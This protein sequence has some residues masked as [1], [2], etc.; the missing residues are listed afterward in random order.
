MHEV[1][2]AWKDAA[3]AA[4]VLV[5]L[6]SAVVA[7]IVFTYTR[8]ANRRRATL[9]MVMKTLLDEAAR[10]QYRE[11]RLI[12]MRSQDDDD[13][14]KIACL[15]DDEQLKS[16]ERKTVLSQLNVYELMALGIRRKLF[17]EGLYKRWYHNQFMTDYEGAADFI[18]RLQAK[19]GSIY[20]E[21]TA[22][23]ASW[24]RDGHPMSSPNRFKMAW[25]AFRKQHDKIDAARSQAAAR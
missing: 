11:F 1:L 3:P 10:K 14:F 20:C 25:W 5:G 13:C 4:G 16:D 8:R 23:Y 21:A 6:L 2:I 19:K 22:L 7:L 17:D 15:A 12:V 18:K 9:D 24:L